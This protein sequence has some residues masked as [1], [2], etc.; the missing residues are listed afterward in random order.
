MKTSLHVDA[1]GLV[2][3]ADNTE[4]ERLAWSRVLEVF[5]FKEDVFAY[6]IIC[7]GFR[8]DDEGRWFKADEECSGFNTLVE[9]LPRVFPGIRQD[10]FFN[11]A[12]PA[13]ETC[14]TT[15]WG[16]AKMATLWR[17]T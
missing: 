2:A 8:L 17:Q 5:A 12:Y 6:D 15:L 16:D 1:E 9:F 11:V 13:F 7:L 10:W 3:L 4:L 14:L